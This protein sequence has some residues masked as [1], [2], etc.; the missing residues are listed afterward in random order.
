MPD[1]VLEMFEPYVINGVVRKFQPQPM[2]KGLS[3]VP[4]KPHPYPTFRYDVIIASRNIASITTPGS[5]GNVVQ[6]QRKGQ[7]AG[8]FAYTREK[9]I[10]DP[11]TLHW[12]RTP[13]E[14][15]RSN[16]E[17]AVMDE[18]MD[19][20][21]R[22]DKLHETF[23]WQ[24]LSGNLSY[25]FEDVTVVIDYLVDSTHKPTAATFWTD[26]NSD[27]VANVRAWKRLI[28]RDGQA[29]P[30]VVYANSV[31]M[32]KL[33][34]HPKVRQMLSDAQKA[35]YVNEGVLT[36]FQ[37]LD[38]VEYDGGYVDTDGYLSLNGGSGSYVP[39]IPDGYLIMLSTENNPFELFDGPSA[40]DEAPENFTGRFTKTWKEPD[41]SSRQ[42]LMEHS[43]IPVL[44]RPEQVVY[45][46]VF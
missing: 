10:F 41:P 13:G 20:G 4:R 28:T 32:D 25:T 15:A 23:V 12:L 19:L 7:I 35:R 11:T 16:A 44:K 37:G 8:S 39:Y 36:R 33:V 17:G 31:T 27:P 22:I 46:R 2:L 18:L 26:P 45:A 1:I 34:D 14:Y 43:S 29:T 3:L 6:R 38:W 5:V 40:D 42:V 24:M 9:K 21:N 30:T